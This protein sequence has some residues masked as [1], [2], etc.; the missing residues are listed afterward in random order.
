M[1]TRDGQQLYIIDF[2][3]SKMDGNSDN[4][5]ENYEDPAGRFFYDD[6]ITMPAREDDP[7]SLLYTL[8]R[9]E[10]DVRLDRR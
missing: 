3:K 8:T 2:G 7:G 9:T 10:N 5:P 4:G 1:I 6:S